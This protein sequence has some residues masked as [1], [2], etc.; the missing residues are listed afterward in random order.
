MNFLQTNVCT[1]AANRGVLWKKVFL[2]IS[3][4]LQENTC[5]RLCHRC[6][7][8]NFAKFLRTTFFIEHLQTTAYVFTHLQYLLSTDFSI[9]RKPIYLSHLVSAES[10]QIL[11]LKQK[12]FHLQLKYGIIYV[13]MWLICE[14]GQMRIP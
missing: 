6:F 2:K 9:F 11:N 7:P 14:R 8:V 5:V 4:N 10:K 13:I 12:L 3:Q 1:G